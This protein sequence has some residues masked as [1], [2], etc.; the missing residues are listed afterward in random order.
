MSAKPA[1]VS[2]QKYC[3][4]E[5]ELITMFSPEKRDGRQGALF[6]RH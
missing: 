4:V 1:Q 5:P 3:H 2:P 6:Q